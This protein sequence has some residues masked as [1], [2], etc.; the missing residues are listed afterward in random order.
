MPRMYVRKKIKKYTPN[1][2]ADTIEKVKNR[3][4]TTYTAAQKYNIH[5]TIFHDHVTTSN[6]I[7]RPNAGRP[8]AIPLEE[9]KKIAEAIKI[10]E[11]WGFG[12]SRFEVM[13][14]VAE[15]SRK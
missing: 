3:E 9:E 11:K 7:I 4:L 8:T 14:L 12:L 2:L 6:E 1:D 13:E 5:M 10:M 15:Y